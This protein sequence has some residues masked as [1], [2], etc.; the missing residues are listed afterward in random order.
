MLYTF[1]S[2]RLFLADTSINQVLNVRLDP[3]EADAAQS[4][5]HY[6][7]FSFLSRNGIGCLLLGCWSYFWNIRAWCTVRRRYPPENKQEAARV[8]SGSTHAALTCG[9]CCVIFNQFPPSSF[10]AHW[11]G[12]ERWQRRFSASHRDMGHPRNSRSLVSSPNPQHKRKKK[13]LSP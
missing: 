3:L 10:F 5:L 4:F 8:R 9:S 12:F 1:Y 6:F 7:F 2:P 11:K 13:T